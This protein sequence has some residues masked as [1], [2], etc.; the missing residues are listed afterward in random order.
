MIFVE[1]ELFFHKLIVYYIR[2]GRRDPSWKRAVV[3][4][5]FIE[6][7]LPETPCKARHN[8]ILLQEEEYGARVRIT[9]GMDDSCWF[10]SILDNS[11]V[12]LHCC[13]PL[14]GQQT[15]EKVRIFYEG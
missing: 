15:D 8:R 4:E 3:L 2:Y 11:A 1:I 10:D 5:H 13:T 7:V 14:P 12:G 9:D 6:N